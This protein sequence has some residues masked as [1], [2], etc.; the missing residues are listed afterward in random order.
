M[1][2]DCARKTTEAQARVIGVDAC[3]PE[4]RR[5]LR[6]AWST[7]ASTGLRGC[8]WCLAQDRSRFTSPR[9]SN[10]RGGQDIQINIAR[11]S[12]CEAV[13]G[14]RFKR[15]CLLSVH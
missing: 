14:I 15:I 5:A 7:R 10:L 11:S 13:S 3:I 12:V 6:M 1:D 4:K 8:W 9:S 2:S